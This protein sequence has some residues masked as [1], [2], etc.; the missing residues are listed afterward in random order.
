[1]RE[2]EELRERAKPQI[3][4]LRDESKRTYLQFEEKTSTSM[5]CWWFDRN[6]T[7]ANWTEFEATRQALWA[8]Q[9][10]QINERYEVHKDGIHGM[11]C[12]T[13]SADFM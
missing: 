1:M 8:I 3:I 11:Y 12:T 10:N 7:H 13:S 5:Q 9:S 6:K 4:L 2:R